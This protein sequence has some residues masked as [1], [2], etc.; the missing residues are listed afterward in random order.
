MIYVY[1]GIKYSHNYA[2]IATTDTQQGLITALNARRGLSARSRSADNR[3][4]QACSAEPKSPASPIS[5][6]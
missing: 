5:Q 1:G 4:T 2:I 3:Q 6:K